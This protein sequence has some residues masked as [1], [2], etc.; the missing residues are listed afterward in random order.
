MRRK[1]LEIVLGLG[2]L[3]LIAWGVVWAFAGRT[4]PALGLDRALSLARSKRFAEAEWA[5]NRVLIQEPSNP[6]ALLLAAQINLDRPDPKP[7]EALDS[8]AAIPPGPKPLAA[9]TA[10]QKGKAYYLIGDYQ[11]A[12]SQWFEALRLNPIIPEAGWAL[13]DLYYVQARSDDARSLV[14]QLRLSEP[15]PRDRVLLLLESLRQEARPLAAPLSI[16]RL[17]RALKANP[18]DLQSTLGLGRALIRESRF[19]DA[20][21]HFQKAQKQAN[22]RIDVWDALLTGLD[23]ASR[24]EEFDQALNSLPASLS[25]NPAFLRHRAKA[26]Q[27][28]RDWPKAIEL[29]NQ[30]RKHRRDE[31]ATAYRLS[32]AL[33]AMGELKGAET[34]E[35]EVRRFESAA[36]DLVVLFEEALADQTI[37]VQPHRKLY[38]QLAELCERLGRV[39]E[40]EAW[41]QEA[42]SKA[43]KNPESRAALERLP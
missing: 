18:D 11:A 3:A 32:R 40:A 25:A 43:P 16:A 42:S 13:L 23:D 38:T 7:R 20:L 31:A 22:E 5:V 8:L 30:A 24:G 36:R 2:S 41:N 6:A 34:V 9:M 35:V 1:P 28:H 14:R 17:E 4:R 12:E 37:G 21:K 19:D 15:D 29:Y 33:R 10:L 39:E 27:N 26:A